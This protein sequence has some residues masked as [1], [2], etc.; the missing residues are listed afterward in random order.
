M[1]RGRFGRSGRGH[2]RGRAS[3]TV[4]NPLESILDEM[5]DLRL[6]LAADLNAAAGAAEAGADDIAAEIMA[7]DRIEVARFARTA[8]QRLLRLQRLATATPETP[9]WRRRLVVALP[10]APVVGAMA[11]SAAAATGV[12]SL[13]GGGSNGRPATA[14]DAATPIDSSF[15]RLVEVLDA[16][17]SRSEVLAAVSKLHQQL[18][19]LMATSSSHPAD[20]ARIA[21]LLR[22]EESLLL[23]EQPPGV[24]VVLSATR[25]LAARLVT[26]VTP[27]EVSPT[28]VPTLDSFDE[29]PRHRKSATPTASPT[30]SPTKSASPKPTQSETPEPTSSPSTNDTDPFPHLPHQ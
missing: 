28:A 10:V 12:I 1:V 19:H 21:A 25:K 23:R 30:A 13:P 18:R 4:D 24:H 6:T 26:R 17:P 27:V 2:D 22:A 15:E 20:A 8:D 7:A 9:R 14:V 16:N 3:T 5:R 11:L 29:Q